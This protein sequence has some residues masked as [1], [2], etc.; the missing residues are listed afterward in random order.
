V[1][2]SLFYPS[3]N[4]SSLF[5]EVNV[6][7]LNEPQYTDLP[8]RKKTGSRRATKGKESHHQNGKEIK[9]IATKYS[10]RIQNL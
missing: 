5:D 8:H 10:T 3:D 1:F 7:A 9:L 2:D 4:Q 6:S